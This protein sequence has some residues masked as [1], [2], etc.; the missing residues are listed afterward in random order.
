MGNAASVIPDDADDS[1]KN[2]AKANRPTKGSVIPKFSDLEA[3]K[4]GVDSSPQ[5]RNDSTSSLLR[6]GEYKKAPEQRPSAGKLAENPRNAEV[7]RVAESEDSKS[8]ETPAAEEN[9]G[10]NKTAPR[11]E[12]AD[13]LERA[14]AVEVD[15]GPGLPNVNRSEGEEKQS[16]ERAGIA[17][18]GA[19][20][21]KQRK[22]SEATKRKR[23]SPPESK[24]NNDDDQSAQAPRRSS[25]RRN[26][27]T[28]DKN[29]TISSVSSATNMASV[30]KRHHHRRRH[31]HKHREKQPATLLATGESGDRE[32]CSD[33]ASEQEDKLKLLLEF[34]PYFGAGDMARDGMVRS[35]LSNANAEELAGDRDEYD[36]TL[37]ILAC[38]YR[39]KGLV[40]LILARGDGAIDVDAVNSAGASALH[41]ACYKDS[42]CVETAI[43][44][45]ERGAKP[46]VVENTYGWVSTLFFVLDGWISSHRCCHRLYRVVIPDC[47]CRCTVGAYG[48]R[49]NDKREEKKNGP[50]SL[51]QCRSCSPKA[52]CQCNNTSACPNTRGTILVNSPQSSQN[53]G[54]VGNCDIRCTP[55]HYAA[56]AGDLEL[57]RRLVGGGAKAS[58]WDFYQYTAVDYAKQSGATDCAAYLEDVSAPGAANAGKK[59]KSSAPTKV[60]GL[61]SIDHQATKL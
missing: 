51:Q 12:K 8:I 31:H 28:D 27:S 23:Q 19:L 20:A 41:F 16:E 60:C 42:I 56:G 50:E 32:V 38:Q 37:L 48:N 33:V 15:R 39:C 1:K 57:C 11:E 54:W 59:T 35:I 10:E 14:A 53:R 46:E 2:K 18:E 34:I 25:G 29:H 17:D 7:D 47:V 58:T 55:L 6:H 4:K 45:L 3:R 9:P 22:D 36:N 21:S 26:D 30:G 13:A 24:D 61:L 40:P 5:E 43:L 44:L 52:A 49:A